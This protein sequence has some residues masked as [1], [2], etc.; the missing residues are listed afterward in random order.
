MN[1][2]DNLTK[3]ALLGTHRDASHMKIAGETAVSHLL[4]Q[5]TTD[6]PELTLL[7]RAGILAAHEQNGRLPDQLR[8]ALPVPPEPDP[9]PVAP[10]K[11]MAYMNEVMYGKNVALLPTFLETLNKAGYRL[12]PQY[13][14]NFL[15]KGVKTTKIQP[16]L[17]P[18]LGNEGRW[19]AQQNPAWGYA[20]PDI[21]TWSGLIRYWEANTAVKRQSFL[22]TLR[23]ENTAVAR[24]LLENYWRTLPDT[25]RHKL[26]KLLER[27]ISMDDEPFLEA[28]LDD[29]SH[30]VRRKA[31][32]LLAYLPDS[33]LGLRMA[34]HV[35]HLILWKQGQIIISF[36]KEISPAMRRDGIQPTDTNKDIS[37]TRSQQLIQ[38][39]GA[40]PLD[41]WI[42]EWKASIPQILNAV[43]HSKWPR[44]LLNGFITAAF[45]QQDQA[46]IRALLVAN[47]FN[48]QVSRLLAVMDH[49]ALFR[50]IM[51]NKPLFQTD[52][53]PLKIN[54]PMLSVL[55]KHN[56]DWNEEM[57]Q[58]WIEQIATNIRQTAERK[59][60]DMQIKSLAKR[61]FDKFPVS[62]LDFAR[63]Q[64]ETAVSENPKWRPT[65]ESI[66]A[67]MAFKQSMFADILP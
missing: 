57:A 51:S 6:T 29:R 13:L 36:P 48:T 11:A 43:Q 55:Q 47:Q 4:R 25:E 20:A 40:V 27:H 19:L 10:P 5:S 14:P 8:T 3:T 49:Q 63:V 60:V 7:L 17:L 45:K 42:M 1:I 41:Y 16:F 59:T 61:R 44:S 2:W 38:M 35:R 31:A 24:Q 18:V 9:R 50:Y 34:N 65:T 23:E 39:V 30:L 54:H 12:P 46:W 22:T 62:V 64:F 37:R 58:F 28:A 21:Y 32:E 67:T 53:K 26:I 15:D 33:R 56:H 52:N 66:L